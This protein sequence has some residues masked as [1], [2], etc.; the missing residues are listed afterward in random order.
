M[1]VIVQESNPP[2]RPTDAAFMD[3]FA[4][5]R[6]S[7]FQQ[8]A[9]YGI[10]Q[11]DHVLVTAH[12]GSGKT[13][14]AEY[15]I[16]HFVAQGRRVIYASPIKALSNQ[17]LYDLRRKFPDISFG[18]LTGDCK[19][20]PDADVLIMTTEILRNSL[21]TSRAQ[22]VP[23]EELQALAFKMNYETDLAA[24]IFDEVHYIND[25]DRGCVWEQAI[26][27]LPPQVQMIMLSATIDQPQV[28]ANW[29][30]STK[31]AQAS[32][33]QLPSKKLYLTST[34]YR[35]VPLTHY[36]WV[37]CNQGLMKLAETK[38]GSVMYKKLLSVVK[39]LTPLAQSNGV[40][41]DENNYAQVLAV[42]DYLQKNQQGGPIKRKFVLEDVI[43]HCK[44][45]TM[46][47]A[48][49][50]VFSRKQ[51]EQLAREISFSL[52]DSDEQH[53]PRLVR[54]EM[55]HILSKRLPNAEEYTTLPEYEELAGLIEKGIAYHHAGMLPVLRELVELL[56]EK[57][58]VKLLIATETFAVGINMPTK[59][60]LFTGLS[61][62][63]GGG[64]NRLL[65]PHE[66]TQMAGRAGRRGLDTVGHVIH[67]VNL[68]RDVPLTYEMRNI[69]TGA[70][71]TLASK[72]Q[73]S[74]NLVLDQ[75]SHQ[76]DVE[77]MVSTVK[78]SLLGDEVQRQSRLSLTNLQN[79]EDK[80][81]RLRQQT[82]FFKTPFHVIQDMTT[83]QQKLQMERN[84]NKRK[85]L[86]RTVESMKAEYHSLSAESE[87]LQKIQAEE[88]ALERQ[89]QAHVTDDLFFT[90]K[91]YDVLS[92]LE[93]FGCIE[94]KDND[95]CND[96][97][98]L[99]SLGQ[100]ARH[101]QEVHPILLSSV[102]H[103]MKTLP[104]AHHIATAL[105][106]FN[107]IKL[108]DD[109]ALRHP[110]SLMDYALISF[111]HR[112]EEKLNSLQKYEERLQV[113]VPS[114]YYDINYDLLE[115]TWAW[116]N[117]ETA[118]DCHSL[119]QAFPHIY[120]GEFVKAMLKIINV[121]QE[122]TNVCEAQGEIELMK[123][124][125]EIAPLLLKHIVTP[126]SL[127]T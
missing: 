116:S 125:T 42:L 48:I 103:V 58:Y 60:V 126:Q 62:F 100:I 106:L 110:P 30:I 70:P 34:T 54:D 87:L 40:V 27:N 26:L 118:A 35:V 78:L 52:F 5:L 102:V 115:L 127:Y 76:A 13:L 109:V 53:K 45:N 14:P 16:Q 83:T 2:P 11:G 65:Y 86:Q 112:V 56:M 68:Y 111:A 18:L 71:Q 12:T 107:G 91:V 24:V 31:N 55:R 29:I 38:A 93:H 92:V 123:R 21:Q 124:L 7:V 97:W 82:Q 105:S 120:V 98:H 69:L 46:L 90:R 104:T 19:E 79:Q 23:Q 36:T 22:G 77:T 73:I 121:A 122:L 81:Q 9:I 32:H 4:G 114:S 25:M 1:L 20:N 113:T 99:T 66:Y 89:T 59:T 6:L 88:Q 108:Q 43:R 51:C 10:N 44:D 47:P 15:A 95:V 117:A 3:T 17:K 101:V 75:L 96:S 39:K 63:S 67:C 119:L 74:Y 50:F 33:R 61:K 28:F 94:S 80:L 84:A 85:Q 49:T 57:G 64:Q 72:F 37:S 8:W 41:F